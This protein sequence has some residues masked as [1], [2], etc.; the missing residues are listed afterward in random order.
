MGIQDPNLDETWPKYIPKDISSILFPSSAG[1]LM[2]TSLSHHYLGSI[3][4]NQDPDPDTDL[5]EKLPKYTSK[6][7]F[8]ISFPFL[9]SGNRWKAG[10]QII[11]GGTHFF[12]KYFKRF[13]FFFFFTMGIQDLDPNLEMKHD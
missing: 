12:P 7:I 8:R 13:F 5:D 11:M 1:E 3:I 6:N 9:I 4:G 10:F 2:G